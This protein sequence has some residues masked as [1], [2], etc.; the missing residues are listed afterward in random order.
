MAH[1]LGHLDIEGI[2]K[3]TAKK[4][5]E[6]GYKT[7]KQV[8][9][10][11]VA[12]LQA[13]IGPGNGH[14]LFD[15]LRDVR[16]TEEKWMRAYC[17]W[18]KGF[19]E[20]RIVATLVVEADVSKWTGLAKPPKGQSAEAFAE[21]VKAVPGYLAWRKQFGSVAVASVGPVASVAPH[22][23]NYG[24]TGF[25]DADLQAK[26]AAAG[27]VLKDTVTSTTAV[28]LVAD[29]AKETTKVAAARKAGVRIVARSEASS[30]L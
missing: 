17:G 8:W 24:M 16:V 23:G 13:A 15:A 14:K 29:G 28:L 26:L 10:A 30:L 1:S 21:V 9:D 27:W 22:K 5:V 25:R 2:S 4:L 11:P 20:T 12:G 6:A 7:L 19:G 18:P 3:V